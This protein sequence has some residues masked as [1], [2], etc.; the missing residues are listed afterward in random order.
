[1]A[2]M[3]NIMN[4]KEWIHASPSFVQLN[5]GSDPTTKAHCI[6][7]ILEAAAYCTKAH[8][9]LIENACGASVDSLTFTGG[10]SKGSLWPQILAD[11]TSLQVEVPVVNESTSLGAARYAGVGAGWAER[12]C[13]VFDTT[14]IAR[15]FE[16][17]SHLTRVYG[18]LYERWSDTYR[19]MLDLTSDGLL[20]P[21]WWPPG[22][23]LPKATTHRTEIS[24]KE[25]NDTNA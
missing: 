2:I 19:A 13:D 6:R 16:P 5:L 17:A 15:T 12:A 7:A 9:G 24:P 21:L 3:S 18:D 10:A 20:R 23:T 4:A 14:P 22:T 25:A 1:M 8:I 11:V